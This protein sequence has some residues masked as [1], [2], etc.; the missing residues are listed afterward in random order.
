M[1]GESS[2]HVYVC[3][4]ACVHRPVYSSRTLVKIQPQIA[5]GRSLVQ[6]VGPNDHSV[7]L[8]PLVISARYSNTIILL[9]DD[10]RLRWQNVPNDK[11]PWRVLKSG[12]G[13]TIRSTK[14]SRAWFNCGVDQDDKSLIDLLYV[15]CRL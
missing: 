3:T 7:L 12:N 9:I 1:S 14:C 5:H 11:Y 2:K 4:C 15:V 8:K 6:T 10:L 13:L